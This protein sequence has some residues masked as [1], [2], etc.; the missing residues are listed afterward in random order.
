[1]LPQW[2]RNLMTK[3][4]TINRP[5]AAMVGLLGGAA[6]GAI[7]GA[8]APNDKISRI[9][10][11]LKGALLGGATGSVFGGVAGPSVAKGTENWLAGKNPVL[12]TPL[13][14]DQFESIY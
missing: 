9:K 1:M 6:T 7:V 10:Q 4:S 12:A 2:K 13:S 5:D 14:A 11:I 3:S 8:M